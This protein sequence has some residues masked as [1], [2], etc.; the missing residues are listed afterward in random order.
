MKYSVK[1]IND[2]APIFTDPQPIR[3]RV[4]ISNALDLAPNMYVGEVKVEDPDD[5]DNGRV[6]LRIAPPMDKYVLWISMIC[7][8]YWISMDK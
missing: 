2:N 1:D 4:E 8:M 7:S 5:G 3:L 6:A